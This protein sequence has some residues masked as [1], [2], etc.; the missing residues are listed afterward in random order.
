MDD[1]VEG[2]LKERQA[3]YGNFGEQAQFIQ[4]L[5]I[6]MRHTPSYKDLSHAQKEAIDCIVMK[7][8]RLLHGNP[9]NEDSWRDIAGYAKL[10]GGWTG[11]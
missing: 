7:I 8:S 4:E 6:T 9:N 11:A 10:G 1:A 5:K 3:Q 2:I